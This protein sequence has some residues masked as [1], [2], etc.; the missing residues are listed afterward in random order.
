MQLNSATPVLARSPTTAPERTLTRLARV[1]VEHRWLLLIG[2]ALLASLRAIGHGHGDWDFFVDASRRL[3]GEPV[4]SLPGPGGLLL[5][6]SNPY[7]L[8]GPLPLLFV[9]VTDLVGLGGSYAIGVVSANLLAVGAVALLE[10]TAA[11][12]D[13]ARPE[14]TLI[15]G[16]V[17]LVAWSELAGYGHIDDA[18]VLFAVA[19]ALLGLAT[20]Q[21]LAVGIALGLAIATKQWGVMFLPLAFALPTRQ[22]RAAALAVGIGVVA[23]APFVIAAPEMLSQLGTVQIVA[24]DSVFAVLRY[25]ALHGPQWVRAAELCGGLLLVAFA[26]LRGRWQ[27]ALFAAIAFRVLIDPATW[28]YY[29]AG[30]VLGALAWDLLGTRRVIPVWTIVTFLLLAEATLLVDDPVLRGGLRA[31]ACLAALTLLLGRDVFSG[32]FLAWPARAGQG[33]SSAP[34]PTE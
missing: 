27:A 15:G 32:P 18:L 21:W 3:V 16:V 11:A 31:F 28:S 34:N 19:A 25:P 20:R 26:V 6:A 29:T 9:R 17:L 8:T 22:W 12:L 30:V 4:A 14:T 23:W 1:A 13:R 24:D 2:V 33:A 5:Y 10:R 7:V